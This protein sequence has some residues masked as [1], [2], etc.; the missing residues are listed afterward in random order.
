MTDE[1][2]NYVEEMGR[3]FE[4][5]K[6]TIETRMTEIES[7]GQADPLTET[8]LEN[9][10]GDLDRLE[11][12]N[13]KLT[14]KEQEHKQ[15]EEKLTRF[16][17][18]LKRP[19]AG[20][21]TPQVDMAVK[22]FD[23]YLRKGENELTP[24]ENKSLTVGDNTAAG[25]IAPPEYV[26]ELIKTVTEVSPLRSIAR[27]RPTTQK[28]V[29][30]PSRTATFSAVFVA[31]QGTRSETTGYTTQQEEIPTHEMYAL[32]DISEQLL[33]DSVFNLEA[34]MQQEF[35]TQFAKAE[36]TKFIT[37]TGV[38]AP[39][40]I[41]IN[42]DV[43]TTNSGSGTVLTAN[44][45]L[46]L[47]HAIKSDYTNNATFVFNRTTLA[48]I[49]KLQDSAGQFVFQAG[50][51]LTGGVPN[52]ILGYPYVEMPDMPDVASSAK[53]VAF[54]DFSRGYM[55]VDRV[56]LAVLRDPFTQ[57]TSGNVRYYARK[58]VG[59]QVVLAEAIRTQTIS[60]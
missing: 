14:L 40:G 44:G 32:V 26:N 12:F 43:G 23:S 5:F 30:M 57:A 55:I 41:T 2:K 20:V 59:G 48:A 25:F 10:E 31:E 21:E 6:S 38:G 28:S 18:M 24:E 42:S 13:Q 11:D 27:V 56:G 16:E 54:G 4:E 35:A 36:G 50:M 53:P 47:V 34:E 1:V 39:E 22:A 17:T 7:K 45:L 46:D 60:A 29:Q 52:T 58:R 3:T 33:E 51:L 49:R 8:K 19:D 15:L 9:I 37:G